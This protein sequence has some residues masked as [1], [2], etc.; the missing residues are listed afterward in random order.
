[1]RL[2]CAPRYNH[3]AHGISKVQAHYY[4]YK[5][6]TN[7]I[8][9]YSNDRRTTDAQRRCSRAHSEEHSDGGDRNNV[10]CG[11][12]R[13][14]SAGYIR[15]RDRWRVSER[16]GH[17]GRQ[18]CVSRMRRAWE[19]DIA[20][21]LFALFV[22][23][24]RHDALAAAV[25]EHCALLCC[26][27][28]LVHRPLFTRCSQ[29]VCAETHPCVAVVIKAAKEALARARIRDES[30]LRRCRR[31]GVCRNDS[32]SRGCRQRARRRA[33]VPPPHRERR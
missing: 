16:A 30:A 6:F 28:L 29:S 11:R 7:S 19:H 31:H 33:D 24:E 15:R 17:V 20:L 22:N 1:M 18:V 9:I 12:V 14:D 23:A 26:A 21:G 10:K 4:N 13:I 5:A 32:D 27:R 8:L 2:P 25:D 3:E